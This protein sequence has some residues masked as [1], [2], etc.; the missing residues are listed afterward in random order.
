[1]SKCK[2]K[3]D[4]ASW[5]S[6]RHCKYWDCDIEVMTY[7]CLICLYN[8]LRWFAVWMRRDEYNWPLILENEP[9]DCIKIK[10]E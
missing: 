5:E 4:T 8:Q 10:I 2:R 6:P 1:M 9:N 3:P 7:A